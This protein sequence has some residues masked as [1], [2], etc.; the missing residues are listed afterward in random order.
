MKL[1][2]T[3]IKDKQVF[4]VFGGVDAE[5]REKIRE[6]TEKSD[7]AIIV[8]IFLWTFLQDH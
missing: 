6:I 2:E 5:Q 1:Y 3:E 7:N 8:T 4:Y